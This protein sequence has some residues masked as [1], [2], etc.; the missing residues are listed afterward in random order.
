MVSSKQFNIGCRWLAVGVVVLSVGTVSAQ[1]SDDALAGLLTAGRAALEDGL[2]GVARKQ[3]RS[4][5]EAAAKRELPPADSE[6][7]VVLLL[8]ALHAE[9]RQDEILTFLE[10]KNSW[11]RKSKQQDAV[12][13][14]R[15]VALY[16][17]SRCDEAL[18]EV[19][20]LVARYPASVYSG[21]THRLRAWCYLRSGRVEEAL[22][23]FA[24]FDAAYGA[25]EE[26]A[27]NLLDWGQALVDAGQFGAG[28]TVLER[29]TVERVGA[30][31]ARDGRFWLGRSLEG[32]GLVDRAV[33]VF[34]SVAGDELAPAELRAR[35]YLAVAHV[36]ENRVRLADAVVALRTGLELAEGTAAASE[37]HYSL[38]RIL[39]MQGRFD[40]AVPILKAWIAEDPTRPAS[41]H[42]QIT[43]ANALLKAGRYAGAAEEF[44]YYL[45]SY[46]EPKGQADANYGR[47]AALF[48]QGRLAEAATAFEKAFGLYSNDVQRAQS[49]FKV[50]DAYLANSQ[51]GLAAESYQ[52][53]LTHFPT[54]T[55]APG[56]LFQHSES[57]ARGG[58]LEA[59]QAGFQKVV[60]R[61]PDR[62]I[63]E[64]SIYR[65]ARLK[66][67]GEAWEEAIG[68]YDRLMNGYSNGLF[69][70][71]ALYGRGTAHFRLFRFGR[72][73]ADF[74][75][76]GR[77]F[78]DSDLAERASF[79]RAMCLYWMGRDADA[80][81]VCRQF[82]KE[83]PQSALLPNVLYWL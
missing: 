60:E 51:Y 4:Y 5:L 44:Q 33:E 69:Y 21:R 77:Q 53:V 14:W 24:T 3:L 63:A 48:A 37:G 75:R 57:L 11:V 25:S 34:M 64:E 41:H 16:E 54:S 39:L 38:G 45:E 61:Y 79:K 50:G 55:L 70:A 13:F 19:D 8:R 30:A 31:L 12:L 27:Q 49:L 56:A 72:A 58:D 62:S 20:A 59:A 82:A 32:E 7:A 6:A 73:L 23:E 66:E 76:I 17:L 83:R 18:K 74:E 43:L 35:A 47:G 67:D 46:A 15:A 10:L 9:G 36:E 22:A 78:S 1:L 28:R 26:Y 29:M 52:K 42:A 2:P 65:M 81:V 40:E 68:V 80:I 71:E